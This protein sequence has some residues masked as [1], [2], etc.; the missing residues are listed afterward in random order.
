MAAAPTLAS[1][2]AAFFLA[3]QAAPALAAQ[4]AAPRPANLDAASQPSLTWAQLLSA[5]QRAKAARQATT[6]ATSDLPTWYTVQPGDSLS[7]IAGRFYGN[8]AA[9]PVLYWRNQSKIHWA[10]DIEVGQTL[11]IPHEPA[12]IPAAPSQ[13]EPAPPPPPPATHTTA[14]YKPRHSSSVHTPT[15]T[16]E[17]SSAPSHAAEQAPARSSSTVSSG[18][19]GGAF[20]QCVVARESGGN[21]QVMNSSGHYGLYQFSAS[22]WAEY[23]GNPA[24]F[25]HASVAEQNQVF[26][27]ALARGGEFNWS[28][29]DGC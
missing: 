9:W 17:H 29:Y 12:K 22:T 25:G 2:V 13:L 27:N 3:Q 5:T 19:P 10:N 8:S 7:T 24:D 16:P 11:R 26:A 18:I 28:P 23:G 6:A 14:V 1:V 4:T 21:P 20:G 15:F